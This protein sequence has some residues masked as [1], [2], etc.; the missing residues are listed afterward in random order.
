[1]N[2]PVKKIEAWLQDY[3]DVSGDCYGDDETLDG[4]AY[5]LFNYILSEVRRDKNRNQE[6]MPL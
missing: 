6:S 2:I 3:E 4:S 5:I 1:M